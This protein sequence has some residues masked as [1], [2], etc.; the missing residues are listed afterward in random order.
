MMEQKGPGLTSSHENTK[1]H[2]YLQK[3]HPYQNLQEKDLLQP[4]T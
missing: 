1:N 3:N 4:K 2:N